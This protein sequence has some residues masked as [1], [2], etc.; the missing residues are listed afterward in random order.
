MRA[1][2]AVRRAMVRHA[3][4]ARPR[5]CC[6]LLIGRGRE[7]LAVYPMVNVA[8]TPDTRYRVDDAAHVELRR[9]L[10]RMDPPI[11]IVGVYHSHPDGDARPSPVDIA[12]AHYPEWLHVIVGLGGTRPLLRAFR[13][14]DGRAR[15]VRLLR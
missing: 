7:I 13:I 3:L 9:L 11:G 6:G 5:E 4:D 12:E 10:R 14:A 1:P 2:A 8:E 15:P